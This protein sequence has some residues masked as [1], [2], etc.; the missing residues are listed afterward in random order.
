MRSTGGEKSARTLWRT[1]WCNAKA[2][3][4]VDGWCSGK[5]YRPEDLGVMLAGWSKHG[6][7]YN[8][9]IVD[10][11]WVDSHLPESVEAV[12]WDRATH[13]QFLQL[14]GVSATDYPLVGIRYDNRNEPFY[15]LST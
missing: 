9:I 14:Y 10:T 12:L 3:E 7:G 11:A 2:A 5:P 1:D 6:T 8:E 4:G 13:T 15:T